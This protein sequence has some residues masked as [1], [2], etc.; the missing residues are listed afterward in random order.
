M[1]RLVSLSPWQQLVAVLLS[2]ATITLGCSAD[3]V[4]ETLTSTSS[5][6]STSTTASVDGFPTAGTSATSQLTPLAVSSTGK[7]TGRGTADDLISVNRAA[8]AVYG[9]LAAGGLEAAD[10]E[11]G[12]IDDPDFVATPTSVGTLGQGLRA[13]S[14]L[15]PLAMADLQ[16]ASPGSVTAEAQGTGVRL[17]SAAGIDVQCTGITASLET[18]RG[19]DIDGFTLSGAWRMLGTLGVGQ[20]PE[21]DLRVSGLSGILGRTL[22]GLNAIDMGV[23]TPGVTVQGVVL[24]ARVDATFSGIHG[25]FTDVRRL[26]TRLATEPLRLHVASMVARDALDA[27]SG[28][29]VVSE[30]ALPLRS[31]ESVR[32]TVSGVLEATLSKKHPLARTGRVARLAIDIPAKN[33]LEMVGLDGPYGGAANVTLISASGKTRD[34]LLHAYSGGTVAISGTRTNASGEAERVTSSGDTRRAAGGVRYTDGSRAEHMLDVRKTRIGRRIG[35]QFISKDARGVQQ[36]IGDAVVHGDRSVTGRWTRPAPG[37]MDGTFTVN[38]DGEL[39]LVGR[40]GDLLA[41]ATMRDG[42]NELLF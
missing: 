35:F 16:D 33:G 11:G 39:E 38:A 19:V 27:L 4:S 22:D 8:E 12:A 23:V 34:K 40:D 17:R 7:I 18:T 36:L 5:T 32:Y 41:R 21:V 28:D 31:G 25:R 13:S 24:G 6:T 42:W 15:V 14:F 2:V 26:N 9:A 10:D 29:L 37:A 20:R 30:V 1:F 3:T